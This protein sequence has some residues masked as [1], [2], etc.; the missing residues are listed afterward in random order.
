MSVGSKGIRQSVVSISLKAKEM[1]C[2][3]EGGGRG[4]EA[5]GIPY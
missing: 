2:G 5:Q 1:N 3:S 4:F